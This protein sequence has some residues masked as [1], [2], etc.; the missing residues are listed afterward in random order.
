MNEV[1]HEWVTKADNDF[2]SADLLLHSG[3]V[4]FTDTACFHCQQCVEKYLKAY[5]TEHLIR[6]ERTHVL[7]DL[8][9]LCL[10]VDQGFKNISTDLSSLEGYAVAIRYPGAVVSVELAEEAFKTAGQIRKFIRYKLRLE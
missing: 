1:T 3:D 10:P 8:L 7:T 5:L 2:Y 9:A 4:P 6:F